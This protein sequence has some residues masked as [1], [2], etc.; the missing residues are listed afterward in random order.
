VPCVLCAAQMLTM[1]FNIIVPHG[2]P[3]LKLMRIRCRR[4]KDRKCAPKGKVT[5]QKTQSA[6]NKLY[7][8]QTFRFAERYAMSLNTLFVTL[9]YSTGE[10]R[11]IH[12]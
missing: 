2:A 10:W 1:G 3:V 11:G 6:F 8:E 7:S 9:I 4:W 12:S 5:S